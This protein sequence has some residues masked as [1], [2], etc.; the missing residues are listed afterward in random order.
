MTCAEGEK[1]LKIISVGNS[2]AQDA[3]AYLHTLAASAGEEIHS[4]NLMI[5]GCSLERHAGCLKNNLDD[6]VLEVNGVSTE[7]HITLREALTKE[8]WDVVTLQQ[9][10]HYSF[11]YGTYMPYLQELS[12]GVRALCPGAEQVIHQTWAYEDGSERLTVELGFSTSQEMY[13]GLEDAYNKAARQLGGARQIPSGLAFRLAQEAGFGPLHRDTFHAQ[14]PQG[15]Y[16]LSAVWFTFFT[17]KNAA[18]AGFLPEGM[19][20]QEK[21]L[22]DRIAYEAVERKKAEK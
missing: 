20:Q 14:I 8:K 15:R 4:E 9:A 11:D 7:K 13:D 21:R 19:T 22:L 17:G 2:F 1:G 5:G 18:E 3:Q 6:Y 10:S 12:D 16:L